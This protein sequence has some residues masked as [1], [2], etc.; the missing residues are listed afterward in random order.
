MSND[1]E[2]TSYH[3]NSD[4]THR[5]D[6]VIFIAGKANVVNR[7]SIDTP[8]GV[9]TFVTDDDLALLE[10]N[11]VFKIHKDSG[12]IKIDGKKVDVEK[13]V[14]DMKKR[15]DSAPLNDEI[16]AKNAKVSVAK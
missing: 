15:D 10:E 12:V 3:Q 4:G 14:Q 7:K 13:V 2:Y 6:R 16:I 11:Q 1:N 5:V 8:N 9:A